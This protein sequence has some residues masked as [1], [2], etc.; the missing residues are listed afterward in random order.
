MTLMK[1]PGLQIAVIF[2]YKIYTQLLTSKNV[3]NFGQLSTKGNEQNAYLNIINYKSKYQGV[4]G[5][6]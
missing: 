3:R 2:C 1:F 6:K 5:K 4:P